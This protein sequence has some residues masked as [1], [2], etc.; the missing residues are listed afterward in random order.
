M[1]IFRR[2]CSTLL[3]LCLTVQVQAAVW[4][5]VYPKPIDDED[6]RNE[7]PLAVL[8]LALEQTGV[9]FQ[10][11]ESVNRMAQGKA[12]ISLAASREIN[13]LW[14]MTDS[15]RENQLMP[16]RIP[17]Y[18]GLIGLRL[19][20]IKSNKQ[21]SFQRVS[22]LTHM[23]DFTLVQGKDWPDTKILQ[24]NG[25]EVMTAPYYLGL[26]DIL[27]QEQADLFPR[28]V[29]EIW[30]EIDAQKAETSIEIEPRLGVY[31]PTA[32]YFFVNKKNIIL[33]NILRSGLEKAVENGEFDK[34]FFKVHQPILDQANL[35]GRKI[36]TLTNP[37]L[38]KDTPLDRKELW[39]PVNSIA[40]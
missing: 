31:Y 15:T 3:L 7:Y 24:A 34:L 20:L 10:L 27:V 36:F 4:D 28:S 9:K 17:I 2:L 29:V 32:M 1:Y 33:A 22:T 23:R 18:K 11:R 16:I 21:A 37:V 25:F 14:S 5:V 13:V 8:K 6:K 26:F 39:F 12:M 38:P 19:F 35:P 40:Q 30:Q